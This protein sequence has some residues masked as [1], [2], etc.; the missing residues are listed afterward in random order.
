M[1]GR[2]AANSA[3]VETAS[4]SGASETSQGVPSLSAAA[5]QPNGSS[6]D[7]PGV[8]IGWTWYQS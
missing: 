4:H 8:L 7:S 5:T 6:S 2:M 1:I 3:A